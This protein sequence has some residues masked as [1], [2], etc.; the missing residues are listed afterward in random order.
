MPGP[1]FL[2]GDS[3]DLHVVD[4]ADLPFLQRLV[5]DPDVWYS[6]GRGSPVTSQ[7]EQEFYEQAVH[8]DD[9]EHLVMVADDDPVGIIGLHRIN[10]TWGTAELGY[11]VDPD[12]HDQGY[13]TEAVGLLT[14][15]AFDHRRLA[16]LTAWTLADN[17]A[18]ARVLEKNGYEEEGILVDQAFVDGRRIDIRSFGLVA[19]R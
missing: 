12:H 15:Y 5:N 16:K 13:A 7:D 3:I 1:V 19:P 11:F 2:R 17:H 8:A 4:E 6:L 18:S 9:Q 14:D 10:P